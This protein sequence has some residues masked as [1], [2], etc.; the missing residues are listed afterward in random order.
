MSDQATEQ[1]L[2]VDDASIVNRLA[3]YLG[4]GEPDEPQEEEAAPQDNEEEVEETEEVDTP[5]EEQVDTEETEP[6]PDLVEVEIE[7]ERYQVPEALKDKIMLQADY[8]R[9]T[10]EVAEQRKQVEAE[11]EQLKQL[12]EVQQSNLQEYANLMALDSQLQKFQQVDW[13]AL[14]DQDPAEFVRLK[15]TYRDLQDTRSGLANNIVAKQQQQMQEQQAN[16]AKIV[17]QGRATLAKEI[18]NWN[19][20]LAKEIADYG[21]KKLGFNEQEVSSVIDPRVVKMLHKAYLYDQLQAKKPVAAKKVENLPKVAKP[22]SMANTTKTKS[23]VEK[24]YSRMKR[25]G[26]IE[27][28]AAYYRLRSQAK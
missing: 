19:P 12:A 3:N 21:I 4:E 5:E 6:E 7:G 10:Q 13:N 22:G 25:T 23:D 14:Y 16:Y 24:A 15:E 27:D 8:T 28:A 17:E 11:R 1:S 26:S 9:K 20:T 18:P 2:V